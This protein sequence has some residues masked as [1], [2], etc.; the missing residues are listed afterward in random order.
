MSNMSYC[1]F[2]NTLDDLRDCQEHAQDNDLSE[3][4]NDARNALL[5]LCA[6]ILEDAGVSIDL[7]EV[8]NAV[9][10]INAVNRSEQI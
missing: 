10:T 9:V 3:S 1:R 4:E 5:Q 7:D 6:A 8:D 2:E